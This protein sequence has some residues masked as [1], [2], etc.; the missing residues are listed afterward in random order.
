MLS[1]AQVTTSLLARSIS[2]LQTAIV[3]GVIAYP[4]LVGIIVSTLARESLDISKQIA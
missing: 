4:V 3:A 1:V 2:L